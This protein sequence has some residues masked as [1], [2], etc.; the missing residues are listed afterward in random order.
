MISK[1]VLPN[2]LSATVA[3]KVAGVY[4]L[5]SFIPIDQTVKS[6]F[7]KL[8]LID[9]LWGSRSAFWPALNFCEVQRG[10]HEDL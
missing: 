5:A 4:S 3:W 7:S 2:Y 9:K 10:P 1:K 6:D 8:T